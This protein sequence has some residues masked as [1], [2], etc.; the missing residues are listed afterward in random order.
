MT[1]KKW[2][3]FLCGKNNYYSWGRD[4]Y[5]S[6]KAVVNMAFREILADEAVLY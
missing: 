3:G 2:V 1:G 4:S 5:R 6:T